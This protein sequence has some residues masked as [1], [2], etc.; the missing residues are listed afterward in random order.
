MSVRIT[1]L[2]ATHT[3]TGSKYL[4]ESDGRRVLVDC[5]LFQGL[6]E[7]RLRNWAALPV[8]AASIDAVVLT[9]AHIDHS[10][11]LPLLVKQ[12]FA[13]RVHC[14]EATRALCDILLADSAHLQE[15]QAD[16]ANRHGYSKHR[17]ALPLYTQADATR[18]LRRLAPVAFERDF[19]PVAGVRCRLLP[20]GHI[21]GAAMAMIEVEGRTV[22][23]S[24]DL[25]RARDPVM[26][27]PATVARADD[28]IVESTYGDRR[29]AAA[30][31]ADAL[32]AVVT[33][34]AARGGTVLVPSFAVGRAQALL[35]L[36]HRLKSEHRIPPSL[37]VYLNSPMAADVTALYVRHRNEHRLTL[38]DC[39]A[40]CRAVTVVASADDSKALNANP[41]PKV[42]VAASG[43]ATG[44][45]VLHHLR[46]LA[47]DARNTI[48]FSGFQAEGT[49]G[50]T[51]LDGAGSIKLLGDIVPVHAEVIAI[52]TLSAH[53]DYVETLDWLAHLDRAPARVFV[54]HGETAAAQALA[55]RIGERFGW[56]CTVPDYLQTATLP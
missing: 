34:T 20:A 26:R 30:D 13:G 28:V 45:R 56:P 10:G 8:D 29:H 40:M 32:T 23:F 15:E 9:H 53:A 2:G 25:G 38:E 16:H 31:P 3:V 55:A 11:Y 39:E 7:L 21:L 12:G 4:L 46:A 50:R 51:M 17:P 47:P 33:R 36:L 22:L 48:L 52:D 1:F 5:G 24:G 19:A 14:T 6:K 49:R 44:G 41:W 42:I 27:P 54:T 37:P 43:M 18:A 35:L